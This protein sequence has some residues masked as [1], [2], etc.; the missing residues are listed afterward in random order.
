M[1][2]GEKNDRLP[3]SAG[4][5][6]GRA[7]SKHL[8]LS[9]ILPKITNSNTFKLVPGWV[10]GRIVPYVIA[11]AGVNH[12]GQVETAI[13]LVEAAKEAGA[14]SVKFQAFYAD[15]LVVKDAPKAEY[16]KRSGPAG[17]SQYEMLRRCELAAAD[18]S[19][20]K[21]RCDE[22]GIDF[23]VTP[24]SVRWV[25]VLEGMEAA[26][27]KI[28]SGN[29]GMPELLTAIGRTG[30]PVILS[31]GMSDMVQAERAIAVLKEAGCRELAV[32]HCVSLYPTRLDQVNLGGMA[33]LGEQTG[34]PVGFSDHTTEEITGA[35]AVAA[36][37]VIL[38]KH[39]TLDREMAGPDHAMSMKPDQLRN[40]IEMAQEGRVALGSGQKEPLPEES[41]VRDLVSFSV[42]SS[43]FIPAGSIITAEMLTVMRPGTGIPAEE[44]G[45][46]FGRR[47]IRDIEKNGLIK[48]EDVS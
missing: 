22:L 14:D 37:A 40:Y 30:K 24:F 35:L 16:Q 44:K 4:P 45:N 41:A 11:E 19:A 21:R 2:S 46:L 29:L 38:E 26:A 36:G 9:S 3:A 34:L 13:K 10:D 39:L 7:I 31:T 20:V 43:T 1:L 47:A 42:A 6:S 23:L 8:P 15:E 48:R 5:A 25:E 18:F 17:E 27:Y 32:L 12:N 33:T 28:G